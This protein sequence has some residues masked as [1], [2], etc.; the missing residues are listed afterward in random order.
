MKKITKFMKSNIKFLIILILGGIVLGE[1][2]VYAITVL[3]GNELEY[4][5]SSSGL[6]ATNVQD[7]IDEVYK[8]KI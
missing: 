5:N 3:K 7:A 2:G 1:V 8:K 6:S 4:S